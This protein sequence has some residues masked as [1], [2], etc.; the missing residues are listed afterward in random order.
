MIVIGMLL[1]DYGK[2][3]T[4]SFFLSDQIDYYLNQSEC[5][6]VECLGTLYFLFNLI[7]R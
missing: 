2:I 1:R 6:F 3:R 7:L 4:I 5:S